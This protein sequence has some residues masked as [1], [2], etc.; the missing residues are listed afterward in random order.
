MMKFCTYLS[1]ALLMACSCSKKTGS[2]SVLQPQPPQDKNWTFET[3]PMW[4]DEFNYTGAPETSK[5]GYDIGGH[6]WGNNE[7]QYYTNNLQNAKVENGRLTITARP[8]T[9]GTNTYTSAR[10]ISKGKGDFLYG[11]IE[12]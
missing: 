11:R 9:M 3:T 7:L 10:I 6:G 8:E 4:S 1:L 12:V 5:W 2:G